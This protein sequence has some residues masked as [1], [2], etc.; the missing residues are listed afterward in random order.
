MKHGVSN[1]N[2]TKEVVHKMIENAS[3][4]MRMHIVGRACVAIFQY[5][6]AAEQAV[7]DTREFNDEGFTSGDAREGSLTAKYYLKHGSLQEWQIDKWVR[8]N[9]KGTMRIAKYWRQLD[10]AATEKLAR[11]A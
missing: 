7:N 9:K 1:M 2:I 4:N 8:L 6:T 10:R 5:Q 3:D 11:R